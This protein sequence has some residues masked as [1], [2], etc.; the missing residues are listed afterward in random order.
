MQNDARSFPPDHFPQRRA[1][2]RHLLEGL[3][4]VGHAIGNGDVWSK[5]IVSWE[6]EAETIKMLQEGTRWTAAER[7]HK[8]REVNDARQERVK[9]SAIGFT[10]RYSQ[11][12]DVPTM[13]NSL[14]KALGSFRL[15]AAQ[16]IPSDNREYAKLLEEGI[17][18]R[19]ANGEA[20]LCVGK[21]T[22][23]Y[24]LTTIIWAGQAIE[25]MK[26][27]MLSAMQSPR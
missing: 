6:R 17:F 4:A 10:P 9:Q 1:L 12:Q 11:L 22:D 19:L 20:K 8:Y 16:C 13:F 26:R 5:I 2:I 18:T 25:S 15:A 3:Q 27:E 7:E 21:G 23:D 24:L 14:D